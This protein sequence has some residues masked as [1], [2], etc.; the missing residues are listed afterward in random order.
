MW[1]PVAA[2]AVAAELHQA[3]TEKIEVAQKEAKEAR[4]SSLPAA[5]ESIVQPAAVRIQSPVVSVPMQQSVRQEPESET[6]KLAAGDCGGPKP[7]A[8]VTC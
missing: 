6:R 5:E 2:E 4:G 7:G 3:Q 1:K 8:G